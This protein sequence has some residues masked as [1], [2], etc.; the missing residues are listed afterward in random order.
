MVSAARIHTMDVAHPQVQAIA[1]DDSG[2]ILATGDTEALRKQFPNAK[3][4]DAGKATIVPG[5]IDAH[6]VTAAGLSAD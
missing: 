4:I 1:F 5:L 6:G 3:R 2:K